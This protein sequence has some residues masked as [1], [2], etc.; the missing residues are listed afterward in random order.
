[1]AKASHILALSGGVGGAKLVQG[2]A[3]VL[4]CEELTIVA[5]T[6]DDFIHLGFPVSPD[7]DTVCTPWRA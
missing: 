3:K 6:A 2:L 4:A 1:M 7:L 5:N